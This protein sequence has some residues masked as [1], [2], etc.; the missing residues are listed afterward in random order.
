IFSP[1]LYQLSYPANQLQIRALRLYNHL[2]FFDCM[3]QFDTAEWLVVHK[4]TT[5]QTAAAI[6]SPKTKEQTQHVSPDGL[7]RSFPK[8]PCLM[9]YVPSGIYFARVRHKGKLFRQSCFGY[10]LVHV[11]QLFDR[12]QASA[13]STGNVG[14]RKSADSPIFAGA[15]RH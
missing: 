2:Q 1:L 13:P 12:C 15:A 9:Q 7:W 11:S 8:A 5:D 6:S 4:S 14:T 10:G 3:P